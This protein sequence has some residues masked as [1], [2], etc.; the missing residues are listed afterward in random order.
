ME[1]PNEVNISVVLFIWPIRSGIG[2]SISSKIIVTTTKL[3]KDS[4]IAKIVSS[5]KVFYST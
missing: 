3:L 2:L 4:S 5:F 1:S